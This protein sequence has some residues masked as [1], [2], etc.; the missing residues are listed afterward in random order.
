MDNILISNPELLQ[1]KIEK[2]KAD[3]ADN[4]HVRSNFDGSLTLTYI[5]DKKIPSIIA[6]L[7]QGGGYISEDYAKKS[8]ELADHYRPVEYDASI[9]IEEKRA[10]M[11]EWWTKH[12]ALL[13]ESGMTKQVLDK[14]TENER[15]GFRKGVHEFLK[16]L[17]DKKIPMVIFSSSGIGNTIPIFLEKEGLLYDNISILSNELLFDEDGKMIGVK[18]PI[19]HSYNKNEISIVNIKNHKDIEERKDV[20]L[21]GDTLGD[22]GMSEGFNYDEIIRIGFLSED[23]EKH[24]EDY[25]KAY[26]IVILNDGDMGYL[27]ELLDKII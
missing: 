23:V 12:Y 2:F 11:L 4:I 20:L 15:A 13:K 24:L 25:K 18:E 3:G 19:I 7:R 9:P 6:R 16:I 21:I 1:E 17:K 8:Q 14:L 26:D 10:K 5:D 22:V 27:N